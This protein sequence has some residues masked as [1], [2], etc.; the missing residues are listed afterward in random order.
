M[1]RRAL[2]IGFAGAA[3]LPPLARAQQVGRI[4]RV[5]FLG[6][7]R[8]APGTGALYDTFIDELRENG[9]S[10]GRNL[11]LEFRQID[12]PVVQRLS[13]SNSCSWN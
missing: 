12:D 8:E 2:M 6:V 11:V 10:E 3:F 9:F 13:G 1:R 7:T 4:F 5:G